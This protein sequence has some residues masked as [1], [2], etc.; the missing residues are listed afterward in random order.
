VSVI[1]FDI[2]LA[3]ELDAEVPA[4]ELRTKHV[5]LVSR[6]ERVHVFDRIAAAVLG[7]VEL[8][9]VFQRVG[10]RAVV[11]AA[12]LP[13]VPTACRNGCGIT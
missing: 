7:V 9:V 4:G 3:V 6:N 10:A 12:I 8:Y 1:D 11:V 5:P 2:D 13:A